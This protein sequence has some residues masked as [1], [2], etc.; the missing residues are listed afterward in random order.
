MANVRK[1]F[2]KFCKFIEYI[3]EE[4]TIKLLFFSEV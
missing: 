4:Y 2:T 3:I 1:F